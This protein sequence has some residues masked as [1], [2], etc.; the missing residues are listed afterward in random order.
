MV[1]IKLS[2]NYGSITHYYHFFYGVLVPL[3]L[4]YLKTKQKNYIITDDCG[5][6]LKILYDIPLNI[7]FKC[8][9]PLSF[10]K[11]IPL[12]S[13]RS[14]FFYNP[15]IKKVDYNDKMRICTFFESS[16]PKYLRD[17]KTYDIIFIER[18]VDEKY[19]LL[20]YS[21][22][23][24][25]MVKKLG[26]SSGSERRHIVNHKELSAELKK[27]YGDKFKNISLEDKPIMYQYYLFSRAKLV[28]AQHGAA[29]ANIIFMKEN[30]CV[31][32]IVSIE[33]IKHEKEDCFK[34]LALMS[35]LNFYSLQTKEESPILDIEIIKVIID[36][37]LYTSQYKLKTL[38]SD[39]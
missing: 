5:P 35:K 16:F 18:R 8:E 17:T 4:Y 30:T 20:D 25:D 39:K 32:E 23:K 31:F 11:L 33:K 38:D 26:S 29:L 10:V 6:M 28:I 36:K 27:I 13:F 19:K 9:T 14:K 1:Y 3:I 2:S 15:N 7:L 22:V 37:L 24:N 34:N 21:K 12:D